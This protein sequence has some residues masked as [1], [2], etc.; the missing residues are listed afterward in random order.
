MEGL[1]NRRSYRMRNHMVKHS[2]T[3]DS[4][5]SALSDPVRRAILARLAQ[6]DSTVSELAAPFSISLPAVSKHLRILETTG[7]VRREKQG[8]THWC[9]LAARPMKEAADWIAC[10]QKFWDEKFDALNQ[11][12]GKSKIEEESP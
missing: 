2:V 10:Y 7:L 5:C 9:R 8:R 12:L 1:T 3:L 6:G 4:T 11:Y